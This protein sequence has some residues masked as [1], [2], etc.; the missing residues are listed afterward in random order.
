MVG[1]VKIT[2]DKSKVI[3][4]AGREITKKGI[5]DMDRIACQ[6]NKSKK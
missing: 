3:E 2:D 6:L 5:Q 1:V 4:T